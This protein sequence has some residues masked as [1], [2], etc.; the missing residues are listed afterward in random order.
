MAP[1]FVL[2]H[3]NA[4]YE[5]VLVDRKINEHKSRDYLALNPAG[6]IPALVHNDCVILESSAISIYIAENHSE[7]ELVPSI[8]DV[9]RGLFLQ[10]ATYLTNTFQ[11]EIMLFEY[12]RDHC[13][14]ESSADEIRSIQEGR[15]GDCLRIVERQLMGRKYILGEQLTVCDFYLFMLSVWA[16]ELEQPPLSFD[17][18]SRYLK[19][20]AKL[21]AVS[22]VCEKE[23]LPLDIYR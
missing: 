18:I 15:I 4:E 9:N 7:Y 11:N 20:L 10:W 17:N 2:E 3:V 13:N 14:S 5:L 22:K 21:E 6:K 16:D 19:S 1:H 12:A 8:G 23:G